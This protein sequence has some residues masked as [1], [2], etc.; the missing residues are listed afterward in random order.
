M[1][2]GNC[3]CQATEACASCF[4][5]LEAKQR[6]SSQSQCS[7]RFWR[8]CHLR[9]DSLLHSGTVFHQKVLNQATFDQRVQ[10]RDPD[11]KKQTSL[12]K[13][14]TLFGTGGLKHNLDRLAEKAKNSQDIILQELEKS[15]AFK[16]PLSALDAA[17]LGSLVKGHL[18]ALSSAI[19]GGKRTQSNGR[20]RSHPTASQQKKQ[21]TDSCEGSHC[22]ALLLKDCF[23][24]ESS[25]ELH[26][27]A[28]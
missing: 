19:G 22:D 28:P 16:W 7:T 24:V 3:S 25:K 27:C 17:A 10:L 12:G 1:R 20:S 14:M 11:S 2:T 18:K 23:A 21:K 13:V 4:Y 9:T 15:Q 26:V 5:F 8:Y 6:V